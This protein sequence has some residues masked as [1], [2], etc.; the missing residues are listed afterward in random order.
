MGI[1]T[2]AP[3]VLF[4]DDDSHILNSLMR[5]LRSESYRMFFAEGGQAAIDLLETEDVNVIVTDLGMP[6]I[7][8]L[9]PDIRIL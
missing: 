5:A 3:T 8:G 2:V 4:V 9:I 1:K 6:E 7:N